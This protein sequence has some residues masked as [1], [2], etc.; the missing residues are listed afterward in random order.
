MKP[1][2]A[3]THPGKCVLFLR[4]FVCKMSGRRSG[5]G[6]ASNHRG[7]GGGDDVYRQLIDSNDLVRELDDIEAI[8]QQISQHAEV[9]YQSWKNNAAPAAS[10]PTSASP[11]RQQ[12]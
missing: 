11:S 10:S 7:S 2:A 3:E 8:S 1:S 6:A 9:L 4:E 5:G 12:Q